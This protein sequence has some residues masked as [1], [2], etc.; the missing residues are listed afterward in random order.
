MRKIFP[1]TLFVLIATGGLAGTPTL[2]RHGLEIRFDDQSRTIVVADQEAGVLLDGGFFAA[3]INGRRTV[4]SDPNVSC[5]ARVRQTPA[6]SEL[7]LTVAE[8]VGIRFTIAEGPRLQC[9]L[10]TPARGPVEFRARAAA[11]ER[12]LPAILVGEKE[13]DR[14]VLTTRLGPAPLAHARSLFDPKYDMAMTAGPAGKVRWEPGETW[15]LVAVPIT[16]NEPFTLRV[17]RHYYRD[18]LGIRYYAPISKRPLWPTA[19]VVAMTWYGIEGWKGNPAQTK[20][21]LFPQ[22]DWVARHL[23]PYAETLVFQLDDNYAKKDDRYMRDIS[24]TIR[25]KGLIPGI[26]FTPFV[27]AP[28]EEVE[29]HADW[30]IHD[31]DGKPLGSFGGVSYGGSSTLNVT[32]PAAVRAWYGMWWEKASSTWNFDFF[33]I[34]G[35]PN[36][37]SVY[38]KAVD[39]GGVEGY[40]KGLEIG[41]KIVGSEKFIN[42]C[43]GIPLEA[44][45]LLDGSRTGGDTGNNP[46]AIDVVLR[47]NFLNNVCWWCDPDAAANL[48]RATVERVRLNAQ[49]RVLTGQQFLTDDVWT[50]VPPPVRRVWQQSFPTLDIRPVNLYRIDDWSRYDLFS[51]KV[52]KAGRAWDVAGL[53]NYSGRAAVKQLD[54][55]RLRLDSE[56]VHVFEYWTQKYLGVFESSATIT[57]IM[58]PYGGDLFAIVP[59]RDERPVLISTSRHVSQGGL[60]LDSVAWDREGSGWR[61]R[62]ASSHLVARDP[63]VL[64]FAA[65][66]FG[67]GAGLST[68]GHAAGESGGA[69]EWATILPERSGSCSW[70]LQFEPRDGPCMTVLPS[71]CD[72]EPDATGSLVVQS[73]GAE[74]VSWSVRSADRRITVVPK[75]GDMGP[76]P[77]QA[78]LALTCNTEG[79]EPGTIWTGQVVFEAAGTPG[80]PVRVAVRT[81]VPTPENLALRAQ[82]TASSVWG[83]GYE[84]RRA[85]DGDGST[86]WNS[87]Q[88]DTDGSWIELTWKE[89]VSFDR[90]VIDECTDF[91]NRIQAWR[92]EAGGETLEEIARGTKVGRHHA[93]DL[94]KA[95]E[96]KRLRLTVEK[97]SVVPT[98]WE[99]EVYDWGKV[100]AATRKKKGGS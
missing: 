88:G 32:N 33:K 59:A 52:A 34:D 53:F 8:S 81:L 76:W 97:A 89:T 67:L 51:L 90:I 78:R 24:D 43:W 86:R 39:G 25:S 37:I 61:V 65:G 93:V 100:R 9:S 17:H 7:S 10:T 87:R 18:T 98:L 82:S 91:G 42:G 71:V 99:I 6:G 84:A 31:A 64:A 12:A 16:A 1:A 57:C 95:I 54:L 85:N 38:K 41:R 74:P 45:G 19:P 49:A 13:S 26:W 75:Q 4:S 77:A 69:L 80:R 15:D 2:S 29:R 14:G 20:E 35:Q 11:G 96:A 44:I 50:R 72:V 60:D 40:R 70:A 66:P 27:T 22:I 28:K 83:E 46:H 30:F 73:T 36:V 21:W 79:L 94:S 68:N 55:G 63:Y 48:F 5:R 23:L 47:W 58:A 56:K 3:T 92:L 62:G